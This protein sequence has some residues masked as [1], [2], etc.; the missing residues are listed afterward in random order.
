MSSAPFPRHWNSGQYPYAKQVDT[1]FNLPSDLVYAGE[2][3]IAELG[4]MSDVSNDEF[5][6][7]TT[8]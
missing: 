2:F 8:I 6:S 7:S 5:S 3:Y 4:V 1:W